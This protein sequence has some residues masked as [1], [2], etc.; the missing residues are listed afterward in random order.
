MTMMDLSVL[1]WLLNFF[2]SFFLVSEIIRGRAPSRKQDH[3]SAQAAVALKGREE[4]AAKAEAAKLVAATTAKA[5]R[6]KQMP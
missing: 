3:K 1:R 6:G 4:K 5:E 2:L